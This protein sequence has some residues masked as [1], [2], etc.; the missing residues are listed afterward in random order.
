MRYHTNSGVI[1]RSPAV[2]AGDGAGSGTW[3]AAHTA[4]ATATSAR[5]PIASQPA[6]Q[7]AGASSGTA[8][9]A[10]TTPMPTPVMYRATPTRAARAEPTTNVT[11]VATPPIA[12]NAAS[13]GYAAKHPDSS[14]IAAL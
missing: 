13:A 10:R 8:T 12:R 7:P 11:A 4:G 3:R 14:S 9:P 6:R 2:R 1:E 5:T